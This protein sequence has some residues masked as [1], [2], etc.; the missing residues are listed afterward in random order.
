M[1]KI[2]EDKGQIFRKAEEAV[3]GFRRVYL[4]DVLRMMGEEGCSDEVRRRVVHSLRA[5][6]YVKTKDE[7]KTK[8]VLSDY[9]YEGPNLKGVL[10][11]P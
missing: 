1:S 3:S 10:H 4:A 2:L 7:D 8:W 9:V 6:G 5:M 11:L